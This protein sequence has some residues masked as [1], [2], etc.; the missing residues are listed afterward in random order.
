MLFDRE[1]ITQHSWAVLVSDPYPPEHR[2]QYI[3]ALASCACIYCNLATLLFHG[4]CTV[5]TSFGLS[6]AIMMI[7]PL[8]LILLQIGPMVEHCFKSWRLSECGFR[9]CTLGILSSALHHPNSYP[10]QPERVE[11]PCFP[12][13]QFWLEG[14]TF[15]CEV[16]RSG[17]P[18]VT[19][20]V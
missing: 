2:A 14:D 20:H 6:T 1:L 10:P 3:L 13:S 5:V 16:P 18:R 7:P 4:F 17:S 11:V 12:L 15:S 8:Y 9:R 19:S